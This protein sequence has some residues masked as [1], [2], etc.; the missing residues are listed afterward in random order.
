MKLFYKFI[1]QFIFIVL[2]WGTVLAGPFNKEIILNKDW[3]DYIFNL[4]ILEWE[5]FTNIIKFQRGFAVKRF[6]K[7]TGTRLYVYHEKTNEPY[8]AIEVFFQPP[9][10][11]QPSTVF[12]ETF[13]PVGTVP[14]TSHAYLSSLAQTIMKDLGGKY[15]VSALYSILREE[16]IWMQKRELVLLVIRENK[17]FAEE[18]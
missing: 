13:Y 8:I 3:T 16:N 15:T 4:N 2:V 9:S 18:N 5:E 6:E 11:D 17:L 1:I 7:P 14:D 12:L 10:F